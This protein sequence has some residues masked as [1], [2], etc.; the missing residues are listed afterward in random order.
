LF[1]VYRSIFFV[2]ILCSMMVCGCS[3]VSE[4]VEDGS[5][6]SAQSHILEKAKS[7]QLEGV[8]IG[9]GATKKEVTE[10]LGKPIRVG[11]SEYGFTVYYDGFSLQFED[12]AHWLDEVNENSKVVLI[13]ADPETVGLTGTPDEMKKIVGTPSREIQDDEGDDSD[14][15]SQTIWPGSLVLPY[16]SC[17]ASL[18]LLCPV[19]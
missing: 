5:T 17:L 13:D 3:V 15:M 16:A 7:G 9:L 11:N 19:S 6:N 12:Y 2:G 1:R 14:S 4:T 10:K 18:L 8:P